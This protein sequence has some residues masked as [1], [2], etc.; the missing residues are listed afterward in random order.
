[1]ASMAMVRARP[2]ITGSIRPACC[3]AALSMIGS[4]SVSREPPAAGEGACFQL[5]QA[6]SS[7]SGI[8][9]SAL[10]QECRRQRE[11]G[12]HAAQKRMLL[13]TGRLVLVLLGAAVVRQDK[14]C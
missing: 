9:A 7:S 4:A 8:K 2:L 13:G 1:M 5:C 12:N 11:T 3:C 6:V 14:R 10:G